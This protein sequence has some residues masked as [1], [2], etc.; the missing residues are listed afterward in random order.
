MRQLIMKNKLCISEMRLV[1]LNDG[2][3]VKFSSY[4]EYKNPNYINIALYS[5]FFWSSFR[6]KASS[7]F[8]SLWYF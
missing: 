1:H 6:R 2:N 3:I 5:H 8:F 4:I 7:L